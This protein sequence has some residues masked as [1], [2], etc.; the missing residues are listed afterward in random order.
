M[1]I[2][3]FKDK[4]NRD[5][6]VEIIPKGTEDTII[7]LT[8]SSEPVV[9]TQKSDGIFTEI[10]S[11]GCTIEI[12]TPEIIE[13]L[14]SENEKDVE[15]LVY[16]GDTVIFSGFLTPY[17]YTQP[18]AYSYDYLQLEAV[19]RLSVLKDIKYE[20]V[21]N[22]PEIL[23]FKEIIWNIL[24]NGAGY[25]AETLRVIYKLGI[26]KKLGELYISEANFFDDD[27]EQSPWT[28]EE[29]LSEICR[30]LGLSCLDYNDE[31]HFIDYQQVA[32]STQY[33]RN[34]FGKNLSKIIKVTCQKCGYTINAYDVPGTCASCGTVGSMVEVDGGVQDATIS[35]NSGDKFRTLS[36]NDFVLDDSTFSYD[37]IYNKLSV[38][39]NGYNIE[40]LSPD[41]LDLNSSKNL[42]WYP[43][44]QKWTFTEYDRKG[45]ASTTTTFYQYH[46]YRLLKESTNWKHRYFRMSDGYELQDYEYYGGSVYNS[47]N[48]FNHINTRCAMIERF[49]YY[50]A[51]APKPVS[52]DWSDYIVF[53]NVDDTIT[54]PVTQNGQPSHVTGG[55]LYSNL[56]DCVQ[57]VLEFSSK[58][59]LRYSPDTGTSYITFNGSLWYQSQNVDG[60]TFTL[61]D[62]NKY[63]YVTTP[64]DGIY[65]KNAVKY[66]KVFQDYESSWMDDI[67]AVSPS[68]TA[69]ATDYGKGWPLLK[70]KLQIGDKFWNGSTWTTT[71]STFYFNFNN[72]PAAGEEETINMYEWQKMVS[73]H[74]FEDKINEECYAIPIYKDDNVS[75]RLS[76]TLYN[77]QPINSM[78]KGVPFFIEWTNL[79]PVIFMQDFKMNYVYTDNSAWWLSDDN[80][81]SDL[82]YTNRIYTGF[83]REHEDVEMKINSYSDNIPISKSFVMTGD[84]KEFL[85]T[86][87]CTDTNSTRLMEYHYIEKILQHYSSKKIILDATTDYYSNNGNINFD[88][89]IKHYFNF[90]NIDTFKDEDNTMK[91][92]I[93]DSYTYRPKSNSINTKFIEW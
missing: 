80:E 72:N 9:I 90:N 3:Y 12:L 18:Y 21:N 5:Y 23:S 63:L 61:I 78:F 15:V 81:E 64:L 56:D 91:T 26:D 17:V 11:K 45:N 30:Y 79:F 77:P 1:Y 46:T 24:V 38:N 13:D 43:S 41:I 47:S 44:N 8:L 57:P 87:T 53:F 19:S 42:S 29:V 27:E 76:L 31:V 50:D 66:R 49:A 70:A 52:L 25:D 62:K 16:S 86:I 7:E 67:I 33:F 85:T 51:K 75:G 73:N 22:E 6:H 89:T 55:Y 69:G 58:E 4:D 35:Y 88:P 84:N 32:N 92:F 65:D 68:R 10:K 71:E 83:T 39:A 14:Y 20:T 28:M 34:Y 37:D 93:V 59:S 82:V 40:E 36:K 74:D 60:N 48:P 2:G 54:T